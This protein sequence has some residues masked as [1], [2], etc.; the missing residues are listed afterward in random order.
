MA[1]ALAVLDSLNVEKAHI[2]GLSMGGFCAFHIA[3]RHPERALS[4]T[5][6]GVGY[7]APPESRAAFRAEC[8]AIAVAFETEGAYEVSKRYAVGPTRVQF[9]NKDPRGH[10]EFTRMLAEHSDIGAAATMRGFQKERPSIYDFIDEMA[11]IEVPV[12]IMAGDEDEGAIEPSMMMKRK[13]PTAGLSVFP[14]TGHTLNLEE[15]EMFNAVL[16]GF[17]ASAQAGRWQPRDA[18]SLSSST[19]GM[20]D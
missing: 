4:A 8:E 2:V 5:I 13:I 18:R 12:L 9:Q 3:I 14:K 16:A 7:G 10:A 20:V 15:P 1:D 6:G 17:I 19:T 11:F